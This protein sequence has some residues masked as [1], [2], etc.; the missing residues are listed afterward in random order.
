VAVTAALC[1]LVVLTPH[2]FP[3]RQRQLS[4]TAL[5]TLSF[6]GIAHVVFG[7]HNLSILLGVT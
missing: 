1:L 3:A 7:I 2:L 5:V 6:Y 4:K